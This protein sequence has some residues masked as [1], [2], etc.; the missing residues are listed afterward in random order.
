MTSKIKAFNVLTHVIKIKI[1][2][3]QKKNMLL[4]LR[5]LFLIENFA[6][7]SRLVYLSE[8]SLQDK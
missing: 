4:A 7:I 8:W 5:N 6:K 2:A 3:T 1:A